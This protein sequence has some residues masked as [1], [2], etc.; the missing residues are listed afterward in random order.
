MPI[1]E[2][3]CTECKEEFEALVFRNDETVPCPKCEGKNIKRLMS[4]CAYTTGG[5]DAGAGYSAPSSGSSGC[6]GC[7]SGNCSSCH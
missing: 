2:Y 5:S 3:K 1:Y 4:A 6:A 7:S